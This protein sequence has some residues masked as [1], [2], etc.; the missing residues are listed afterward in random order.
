MTDTP[1]VPAP[2]ER[3]FRDLSD[4]EVADIETTSLLAGMS[5]RGSFGWEELLRSQRILIVSE[6]GAGKTYECRTQQER[7]WR[8]G[9]AAFFLDLATL[10][11]SSVR[12]MLSAEEEKRLDEWLRSQ[13]EIATFF[14][15]SIDE[16]NLTLGKFDQA[17]KQLNKSLEGQ[18]GRVCVV[19]TTRPVP[20]D[21]ALIEQYLTI[22]SPSEAEP[23]AEAFADA[24]MDRKKKP[25]ETPKTRAWRSVGLMPL[26]ITQMREFAILQNVSDPDALLDDIR[27]RDAEEFAQ[28]PQDLIELCSDW[29]EHQRIRTHRKQVETNVAT[30]LKSR[31]DRKERAQL[32]QEQAIEGASRLALAAMLTRKLTLRHSAK[33]DSVEASEAALDVSKIL[34]DLS[35]DER[36]TLLERPLFGFASYG[37][38]RF[39]HR[40]VVEYLAAKRLEALRARGIPIKAIKRLI[41]TETA[42]GIRTVRPSMRPVAAWLALSHDSMFDDIVATDPAVVLDHGDPD[43]DADTTHQGAGSLRWPVWWWRLA[44]VKY[45]DN[46][47]A[48]LRIAGIGQYN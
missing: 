2:I 47:G 16:L 45:T 41:F 39:H 1:G 4:T 30:K 12:D 13:S 31:T 5:W 6:A 23:T 9:D 10:A 43:L 38:V 25:D 36:A 18:L 44:R 24:V 37:R 3:S 28:R 22:P 15:D 48:P 8:A 32:S 33:S 19:I 46:S 35:D 27:L 20:V 7:L 42:Q 17:L 11:T 34:P 14:L 21:R 29:R 26:S 40:S